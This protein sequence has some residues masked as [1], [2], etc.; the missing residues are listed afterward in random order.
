MAP[1][2][3]ERKGG[4]ADDPA[5]PPPLTARSANHASLT[6]LTD[7]PIQDEQA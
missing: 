2:R 4:N 7:S 1:R 6:L 3:R 5:I